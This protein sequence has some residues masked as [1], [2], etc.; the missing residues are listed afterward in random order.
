MEL[1]P[2]PRILRCYFDNAVRPAIPAMELRWDP[3]A[4]GAAERT[5]SLPCRLTLKGAAPTHFGVT[6]HRLDVNSYRVH[7]LWD[8]MSFCW[9]GLTR[10]QIMTTSLTQVLRALGTDLWYLLEQPANQLKAA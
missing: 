7:L 9:S 5:W 8:S 1:L 3:D 2:A 10:L 6:I 4:P